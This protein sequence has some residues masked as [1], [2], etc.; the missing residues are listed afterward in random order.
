[1][2]KT[3]LTYLRKI[4]GIATML[5]GATQ[6]MNSIKRLRS[7]RT[8]VYQMMRDIVCD[9]RFF[10]VVENELFWKNYS[11]AVISRFIDRLTDEDWKDEEMRT[12]KKEDFLNDWLA[13]HIF[14]M[15][16][17]EQRKIE[18]EMNLEES[19]DTTGGADEEYAHPSE[20]IYMGDGISD[21]TYASED[22]KSA[23]EKA[24]EKAVMQMMRLGT[25]GFG[26]IMPEIHMTADPAD[27]L[28][29][30][31]KAFEKESR[32]ISNS[33]GMRGDHHE[34]EVRFLNSIDPSLR[35]L[36][37]VIGRRGGVS[38][39]SKGRFQTAAH[40]DISGVTMG[41]NLNSL[42]PTELAMLATPSA[43]RVFLQRYVQK[44]LQI[45]SSASSSK[46]EGKQKAGP[47]YICVDTS[48]S[49]TGEP[50][51]MAKTLALAISIVAQQ[52]HRPICMVNYS[53]DISFFIL[54]DLRKQRRQFLSFLSRSYGG[55]NDEEKLFKFLFEKLPTIPRYSRFANAFKGA[56]LLVIS[57]FIWSSIAKKVK[58]LLDDARSGGMKFYAL[59]VNMRETDFSMFEFEKEKG[60]YS[61]GYE[62]YT[63]CDYRYLNDKDKVF[64]DET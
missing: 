36:A 59:M 41:D 19:P 35:R 33:R 1:M 60:G 10:S 49:M 57:D 40:S 9:A 5:K 47:I 4:I 13:R 24:K 43:E 31:V 21:M 64:E 34:T 8:P 22:S 12:G 2:L 15:T 18:E 28:P 25:L 14:P 30:E 3:H 37:E 46:G 26:P 42:L 20:V 62:F 29:P 32:S 55:G 11:C 61:S 7:A 50:E 63:D 38:Y 56:D 17:A 23:K 45:F 58:S 53:D 48:G 6:I 39:E 51:N 16:L 54:T 52:E 27:R 44:R